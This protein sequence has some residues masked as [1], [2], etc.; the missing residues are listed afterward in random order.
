[1]AST[2][3]MNTSGVSRVLVFHRDTTGA[4]LAQTR[5]IAAAFPESSKIFEDLKRP[6]GKKLPASYVKRADETNAPIHFPHLGL[7]LGYADKGTLDKLKRLPDVA[8]AVP[9]PLLGGIRPVRVAAAEL[10]RKLTWGL[11]RLKIDELWKQGLTGKGG[12]VGHLDTGLDARHPALK[13]RIAALAEWDYFGRRK[14]KAQ[15]RD[16]QQHGTHTAG[17]ICGVAV[18]GRSVGVA[19]GATLCSGLV[20]EGGDTL[21][22]ILGGLDWLVSL[23]VRVVSLSLGFPGYDP[24]F[25]Q[26]VTLLVQKNVLPV[27]AIGNEGPNTSRSPGN[28]PNALAAGAFGEDGHTA[29][30]SSSMHF[31]RQQ[32]P[33]KPDLVAPGVD[34]ISAKP[35]GGYQSM[36]GT[37]MA[38]PHVAG[39]AALLLEAKPAAAATEIRK[40]LES[41]CKEIAGEPKSRHGAG[42]IQPLKALQALTGAAS[43]APKRRKAPKP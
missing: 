25:Q 27:F 20:I 14:V 18:Q 15:P 29:E 12:L 42:L 28:Y 8:S 32:D 22:R 37:S 40:A 7:T 34:V 43:V 10:T 3:F 19:P 17:T 23:E 1:M 11:E 31:S 41:T 33:D 36:D 16:S 2:N 21:A 35:G 5:K 26:V 13:G 24:A 39:V 9:V 4:G 30:F 6:R 38:T